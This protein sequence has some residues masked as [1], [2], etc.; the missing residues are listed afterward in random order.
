LV[1][2]A[3][4]L[5]RTVTVEVFRRAFRD[6]IFGRA[7][8]LAYYWLFSIFPLLLFLTALLAYLPMPHLFE[9]LFAHLK[10]MLPPEAYSLLQTIFTQITSQPRGGLLSLGILVTIWAS[11]SGMAAIITTLNIA[12]NAPPTRAWWKERLLALALTLALAIFVIVAFALLFFGESI[13]ERVAQSYGYGETF[14]AVWSL[15]QWVVIVGF[16]LLALDALYYFA[17]NVRQHWRL[18]SP[19]GVFALS[20]WLLT[21]FGFKLYVVRFGNY[22]ATYGTLGGVMILMLWFYLTGLAILLGGEINSVMAQVRQQAS[23][24]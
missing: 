2:P 1:A 13:G 14:R 20:C 8:Q 16:V 7:A 12:Y 5:L 9:N 3:L 19:G 10:Q 24:Q 18:V 21:T 22:N 11:S 6:D 23:V 17:P 15:S 4:H